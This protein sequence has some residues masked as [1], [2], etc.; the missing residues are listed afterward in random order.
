MI[1]PSEGFDGEIVDRKKT[2][3][4][5]LKH[6]NVDPRTYKFGK[7][8]IFFRSGALSMLNVLCDDAISRWVVVLQSRC[9]GMLA[10]RRITR[11]KVKAEAIMCIQEAVRNHL[12]LKRWNWWKLFDKVRR[13]ARF[14]SDNPNDL[15]SGSP[16]MHMSSGRFEDGTNTSDLITDSIIGD[17]SFN[18]HTGEDFDHHLLHHSTPLPHHRH[19]QQQQQLGDETLRKMRMKH[20]EELEEMESLARSAERKL[21][22]ALDDASDRKTS[23]E[24]FAKELKV[25]NAHLRQL[26]GLIEEKMK[27]NEDLK[28]LQKRME[29]DAV[30]KEEMLN[31]ELQQKEQL[32]QEIKK[33]EQDKLITKQQLEDALYDLSKETG[34]RRDA[35]IRMN[36]YCGANDEYEKMKM[37]NED[38]L[39][40]RKKHLQRLENQENKI[41]K[42]I[43]TISELEEKNCQAKQALSRMERRNEDEGRTANLLKEMQ[44]AETKM[45]ALL[46]EREDQ[47]ATMASNEIKL[48]KNLD[49]CQVQF[50]IKE[51]NLKGR[52]EKLAEALRN[53]QSQKE[54]PNQL[55]KMLRSKIE[56]MDV[57]LESMRRLKRGADGE[58]TIVQGQLTS[59]LEAK[60]EMEERNRI[61]LQANGELQSQIGE[62]ED[63]YNDLVKKYSNLVQKNSLELEKLKEQSEELESLREKASKHSGEVQLLEMKLAK[64]ESTMVN[65]HVVTRLEARMAEMK[66]NME[67]DAFA[68]KQAESHVQRLKE[69]LQREKNDRTQLHEACTKK[70][71]EV[72]SLQTALKNQKSRVICLEA[73][74]QDLEALILQL[75][76]KLD[77]QQEDCKGH[78]EEIG[79]LNRRIVAIQ[80][81]ASIYWVNNDDDDDDDDEDISKIL[82]RGKVLLLSPRKSLLD[83]SEA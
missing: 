63:E 58:V 34:K 14:C 31:F 35:E 46:K 59:A 72:T 12:E 2:T 5:I 55:I 70:D 49:D 78:K 64:L 68:R 71:D 20:S 1:R 47:L 57:E 28:G 15:L 26:N 4:M 8:Q 42:L 60:K 56:D 44:A 62:R 23:L 48:K 6:H 18:N 37:Q 33:L 65:S 11:L 54:K 36:L 38:L 69:L 74:L 67:L 53:D 22:H 52:M 32:L 73:R 7:T 80:S 77:D 25:K 51:R 45:K 19:Q 81:N 61:L 76:R 13:V 24:T 43:E 50:K 27:E 21:A 79:L 29:R 16:I 30:G 41:K 10:R 82:A 66:T 3:E 40:E 9:R 83:S 17:Y 75:R 39:K